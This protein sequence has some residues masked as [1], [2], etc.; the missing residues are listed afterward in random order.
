MG[1]SYAKSPVL[2]LTTTGRKTGKPRTTPVLYL[3]DADRIILVA[4][5]AGYSTPV[6]WLNLLA[7]PQAEVEIGR[8]KVKMVARQA[9]AQERSRL[10][11]RL[12]VMYPGYARYQQRTSRE[13]PVVL[14]TPASS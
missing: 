10:W 12:L 1:G 11:P 13:I 5:N 14:L 4:A 6:W 7:T 3:K 9:D 2:L 8:K